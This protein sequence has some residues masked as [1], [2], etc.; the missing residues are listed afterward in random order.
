MKFNGFGT[1][2]IDAASPTTITFTAVAAGNPL[3]TIVVT[4][5][6]DSELGNW[7]YVVVYNNLA[8]AAAVFHRTVAKASV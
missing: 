1:Y 4:V 5:D 3:N 8:S 7:T 6:S 2:L